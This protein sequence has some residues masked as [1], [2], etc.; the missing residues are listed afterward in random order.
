VGE[1][2]Q[3][4]Y[5]R[6]SAKLVPTFADRGCCV[7]SATDPHG[8]ILSLD[9]ALLCIVHLNMLYLCT[10]CL[11]MDHEDHLICRDFKILNML[12]LI[13]MMSE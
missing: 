12:K 2:Y 5:R 8:R 3:P 7:V 11:M 1:L 4:S 9:R 13:I 6:L 10:S